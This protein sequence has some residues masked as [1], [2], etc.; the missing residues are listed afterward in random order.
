VSSFYVT[1]HRAVFYHTFPIN[2][3]IIA[4]KL[5]YLIY[6]IATSKMSAANYF[7]SSTSGNAKELVHPSADTFFRVTTNASPA[8]PHASAHPDAVFP[9]PSQPLSGSSTAGTLQTSAQRS[10][11]GISSGGGSAVNVIPG[12]Y[13]SK[14]LTQGASY[15]SI[16]GVG[17]SQ[18]GQKA[19][20]ETPL[21]R[22]RTKSAPPPGAILT[23]KQEHC[24]TGYSVMQQILSS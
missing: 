23:G 13:G 6:N 4:W 8:P 19:A 20:Q 24:K 1:Q 5:F 14:S 18:V 21:Q 15:P 17:G 12:A 10:G 9:S 16:E 2:H 3:L 11:Y 7:K 22:Q